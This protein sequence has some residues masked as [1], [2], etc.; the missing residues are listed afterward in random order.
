MAS[1]RQVLGERL[2]WGLSLVEPGSSPEEQ[3]TQQ[4]QEEEEEEEDEALQVGVVLAEVEWRGSSSEPSGVLAIIVIIVVGS[5]NPTNEGE[6][7]SDARGST[8]ISIYASM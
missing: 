1:Y 4:Q 6:K 3:K 7:E 2:Y 8:Y 5:V